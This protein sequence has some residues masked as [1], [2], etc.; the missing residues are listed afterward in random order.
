MK[1]ISSYLL[2]TL[3]LLIAALNF[4]LILKPLKLVTGGTQGF[5]LL[6]SSILKTNP[7]II[8]LSLNILM[9]LISYFCLSKRTTNGTIAA[10]FIYPILVKLTSFLSFKLVFKYQFFFCVVASLVCGITGALIYKLGFSSG[11]VSTLNLIINK[12]L[13]VNVAL[14]NLIINLIII[15]CG[16]FIFGILKGFYSI[17]II[18]ISSFC[19]NI[20]LKYKN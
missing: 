20:I 8:I 10:S 19:I 6:I 11:G 2:L 18:V 12:Y 3:F 14:C 1:K 9:L 17:L 5:A 16:I 4:N 7:F 15:V 13:K